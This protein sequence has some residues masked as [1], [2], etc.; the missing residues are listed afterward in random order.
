MKRDK[1]TMRD[2][3]PES[4]QVCAASTRRG[5]AKV[6]TSS[7]RACFINRQPARACERGRWADK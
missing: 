6:P 4:S 7:L 3:Y 2:E 1:D 5:I